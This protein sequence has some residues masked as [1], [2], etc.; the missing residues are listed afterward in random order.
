MTWTRGA[1]VAALALAAATPA[2][3]HP[4][5]DHV[6]SLATG[7]A[8]PFSGFDHLL[9]MVAVG[10]WA[11]MTGGRAVWAWPAAFVSLMLVG[12]AIGAAHV[13][14]PYVE[15]GI[16]ASVIVLGIAV[17][18]SLRAPTLL[19]GIVIGAFALLHGYAHGVELPT[20]A[21]AVSF[22]SGFALATALLHSIGA[23]AAIVAGRG[24]G[25]VAVRVAGALVAV[26][27]L[28]LALA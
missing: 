20:G 15:S 17:T 10:L 14:V 24:A 19:G 1:C 9:A 2:L 16:L 26:A 11:G 25:R 4:G 6:H 21:S 28:A 13:T 5:A 22:M 3:A 18:A 27:G 23:T 8:H 12:G 7:F